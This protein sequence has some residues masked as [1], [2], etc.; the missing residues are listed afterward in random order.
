MFCGRR[1]PACSGKDLGV[2]A[3]VGTRTRSP[4]CKVVFHPLP[5]LLVQAFFP[6]F[7]LT[8]KEV[9]SHTISSKLK[10]SDIAETQNRNKSKAY[11]EELTGDTYIRGDEGKVFKTYL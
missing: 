5:P 11:L 6:L 8:I 4:E 3:A 9:L 1:R 7:Y 10:V 2:L